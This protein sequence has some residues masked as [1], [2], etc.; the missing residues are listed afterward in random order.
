MAFNIGLS[1]IRAAST[2]L[3]VTGNNIAN[4]S[5]TGFKSSRTEFGD[6]YTTSLLGSGKAP[7]GSGVQVANI[8]Q[9]FS[10]GSISATD[11]VLDLAIDGNGFFMLGDNGVNTYT[12][13]GIFSLDKEGYVVANNP[14]GTDWRLQ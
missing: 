3:S 10:Q 7:V 4:A 12:R 9:E 11:N 13:S 8:R 6:L 2:D 5:T 14:V 1:G